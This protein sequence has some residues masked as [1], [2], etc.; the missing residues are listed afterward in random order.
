VKGIQEKTREVGK[1]GR[2][3]QMEPST[4]IEGEP[5]E[6]SGLSSS[7]KGLHEIKAKIHEIT[8]RIIRLLSDLIQVV[9]EKINAL[10]AQLL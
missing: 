3:E 1:A 6:A 7:K 9:Q 4:T 8:Q 5:K 2:E 10:R